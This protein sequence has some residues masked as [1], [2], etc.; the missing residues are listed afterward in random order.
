MAVVLRPFARS[1]HAALLSWVSGA[2]ELYRF[3]GGSLTWPMDDDRLDGLRALPGVSEWTA[4]TDDGETFGHLA[5]VWIDRD[6]ARLAR[7]IV[8]PERRGRGLSRPMVD[9]AVRMLR[10]TGC[11]EVVLHV[12]P[13]N[14]PA[15]RSYRSAGFT[16]VAPD[17]GRP[18]FVRMSL[19]VATAT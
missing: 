19:R 6:H 9:A 13:G 10:E 2:E 4:V 14:D 5:T 12:V 7:V 11:R 15:L 16:E 3:S 8:A 17:P 18:Q 1:D